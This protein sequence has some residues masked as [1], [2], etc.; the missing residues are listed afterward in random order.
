MSITLRTATINDAKHVSEVLL[1]SRKAFLSYAPL[2]HTD[3]EV[4]LWIRETLIPTG[5]VTI[6]NVGGAVAGILATSFETSVS[7]INQLYVSP[8]Y[9]GQGIG[10]RLLEHALASLPL[11]VRL[12]T[13][14]A[15]SRARI[16]YERQG[17]VPVAFSDGSENEER[18]PD[19]LYELS[20]KTDNLRQKMEWPAS[21]DLEQ[22][23]KISEKHL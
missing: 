22:M 4:H 8:G 17:F 6:A 14:Q 15:N 3:D 23:G 13:F 18:C 2:A 16:F 21:D 9:V 1:L 7:W 11:P 20:T 19:V 5:D 10:T 12:Y